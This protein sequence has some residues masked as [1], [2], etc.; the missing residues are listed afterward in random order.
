MGLTGVSGL[1]VADEVEDEDHGEECCEDDEEEVDAAH[2]VLLF[3][4]VL[5]MR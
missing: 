4:V 5:L 2:A 1:D 3:G